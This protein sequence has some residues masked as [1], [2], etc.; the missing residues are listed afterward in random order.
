MK[1]KKKQP[2]KYGQTLPNHLLSPILIT[3]SMLKGE[4]YSCR[5]DA[6]KK[7]KKRENLKRVVKPECLSLLQSFLS[8]PQTVSPA[9]LSADGGAS[10]C[11]PFT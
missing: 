4:L 2:S 8:R 6:S 1:K 11:L 10:R 3:F 9:P 7:K 5:S